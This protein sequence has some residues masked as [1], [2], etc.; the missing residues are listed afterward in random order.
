MNLQPAATASIESERGPSPPAPVLSAR[1][2][3]LLPRR[4]R[5][6]LLV[7]ALLSLI[8]WVAY[9]H[10]LDSDFVNYDDPYYVIENLHVRA[11]LTR[12]AVRWAFSPSAPSNES[13]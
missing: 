7:C 4:G 10:V 6:V 3:A 12:E 1:A 8:T 13:W 5:T 11:G 2:E 9:W